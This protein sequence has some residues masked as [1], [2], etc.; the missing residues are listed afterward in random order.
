MGIPGV[1]S[2]LALVE[3]ADERDAFAVRARR[4]F[5]FDGRIIELGAAEERRPPTPATA[6]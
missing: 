1:S 3:F 4:E 6:W 2:S 5:F